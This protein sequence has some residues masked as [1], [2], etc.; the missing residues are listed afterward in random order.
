MVARVSPIGWRLKDKVEVGLHPTFSPKHKLI[1]AGF[2]SLVPRFFSGFYFWFVPGIIY[3]L[4]EG[5][6][7]LSLTPLTP[8]PRWVSPGRW[9]QA[10]YSGHLGTL[11]PHWRKNPGS[12]KSPSFSF[13]ILS[14]DFHR[15]RC[16][17]LIIA[18]VANSAA[19]QKIHSRKLCKL[20]LRRRWRSSQ[21]RNTCLERKKISILKRYVSDYNGWSHDW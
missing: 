16:L 15:K 3:G 12:Y 6:P 7:K 2:E 14:A 20:Q 21:W 1:F 9:S 18:T 10:V 5:F 17:S 19:T 11:A 13:H 4:S 8:L